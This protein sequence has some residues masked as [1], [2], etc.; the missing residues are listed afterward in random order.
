MATVTIPFAFWSKP[1]YDAAAREAEAAG[2]MADAQIRQ[3]ENKLRLEMQDL[4]ARFQAARAEAAIYGETALV[5]AR[6]TH[7]AAVA[8]YRIGRAGLHT[9]LEAQ[10]AIRDIELKLSKSIAEAHRA[11]AG[12]ERAVGADLGGGR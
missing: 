4:L 2:R 1:K 6:Q 10:R 11:L 7:E 12:L 9:V 3:E 5:Q 8:G